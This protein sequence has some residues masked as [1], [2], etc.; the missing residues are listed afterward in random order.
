LLAIVAAVALATYRAERMGLD[1]DMIMS[2]AFWLVTSGIIGARVFY[3]IEYWQK[4]QRD[5]LL[6]TIGSMLNV[7][8]GGLVVYG[9]LLAGGAALAGFVWRYKIP[10]L[11]LADLVAPSVV[12]GVAIG[13]IGCFMNGCCYGGA[14]DLPWAVSFPWGSPPHAVQ[15]ER[16]QAPIQGLRFAG[17]AF[18]PAIIASVEPDSPAER[19][20]LAAGQ[21][22]TEING[23]AAPTVEDAE[24]LLIDL[25][26]HFWRLS[27]D[28]S[29]LMARLK[30]EHRDPDQLGPGISIRVAGDPAP[31]AW[32]L[33]GP[34]PGSRPIHPTQLYSFVESLLLCIF[35]LAYY[36]FRTRDG[37]VTAL[38]M[39]IHPIS[40]FLIEII[41]VDEQPVFDTPWSISQNISLLILAGAICLWIYIYVRPARIAWPAAPPEPSPTPGRLSASAAR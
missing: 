15:V 14:S 9:S 19:A 20:G 7:T 24:L 12:L 13:R 2:L 38:T 31:K 32:T 26:K 29:Y 28:Q 16:G 33:V 5:T 25:G 6:D 40:R 4:F 11:A 23:L 27:G 35:L 17:K 41:R 39:T 30:E 18:D 8:Q 10:G 36:P 1:P 22:I 3:I 34:A 21:R 37:E